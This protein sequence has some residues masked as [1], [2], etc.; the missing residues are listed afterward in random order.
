MRR[1]GT[2]IAITVALGTMALAAC[3]GSPPISESTTVTSAPSATTSPAPIAT[4]SARSSPP[5]PSADPSV[6]A[7]GAAALQVYR[8][9]R[10]VLTKAMR[11][12]DPYEPALEK[13]ATDKALSQSRA[14]LLEQ[15]RL[16]IVYR[17]SPQVS[18]TVDHVD[19]A[20]ARPTVVLHDCVDNSQWMPVYAS[21]GDSA[22]AP[23]QNPRVPLTAT[24]QQLGAKWL[25]FLTTSDRMRTC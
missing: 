1:A 18:P 21:S 7:A 24:V 13:Y 11:K 8:N 14:G 16:G 5:S 3:S 20:A 17:G 9:Y 12:A 2:T 23:N 22:A 15:Q 10:D 4:T 6:S 25:V 19:L